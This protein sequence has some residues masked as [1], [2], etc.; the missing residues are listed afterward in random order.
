MSKIL[1]IKHELCITY[2]WSSNN[3]GISGHTFEA[4][5]YYMVLKNRFSTCILLAEDIT[6]E[7]FEVAIRDKYNFTEEEIEDILENLIIQNRPSLVQ[8][9][10]ILFTDGGVTSLKPVTLLFKHIF[11][12]ACGDFSIKDNN[13]ENTHIF[14][15]F[16]LYDNV[17]VN[18]VNYKKKILFDRLKSITK[19]TTD[20]MML[21][22]TKNCRNISNDLYDELVKEYP[23]N[24]ICLTNEENK[25]DYLPERFQFVDMP[26]KDLFSRFS[27]YLYTEVP[28]HWDCSPR[29][30][31]ECAWYD[32][33]VIY[34]N[35]DYWKEDLG[36][37]WRKF[38]IE[39][40]FDSIH[41]KEDD[42]IIRLIENIIERG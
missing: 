41:L 19:D 27:T 12:M 11:H 8:G 9:N 20:T 1:K 31:A 25:V 3:H 35:I 37:S 7:T 2:S 14:Q 29:F 21:Y 16:R 4:I 24:F 13:K 23:N 36:L 42:E 6:A 26:A 40:N 34:H 33:D 15:D 39:C 17:R 18:G 30:I 22:G 28:R 32:I 5:E 10:M 38:D